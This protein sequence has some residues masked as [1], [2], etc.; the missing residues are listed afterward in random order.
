MQRIQQEVSD[1]R[2]LP[3]LAEVPN[4]IVPPF[5]AENML[6]EEYINEQMVATLNDEARTLTALGMIKPTYD[7]VNYALNGLI[8]N[9]GGF[10]R[11][12]RKVIYVLG[13]NFRAV[14]RLIYSHEYN[15]ALVDQSYDIA[16]LKSPE[17]CD[18]NDR[19]EAINALIEGDATLTMNQWLLQ[20][21]SP[22]DLKS[23]RSYR[24]PAQA[25]PEQSPPDYII[26][27]LNFPYEYGIRFVQSLYDEG[28]WTRVNQVYGQLPQST[29]QIMHFEKY[30]ASEAPIPVQDLPLGAVLGEA[31]RMLQ[32][33]TL[34][35]W[36][37]Y[38]ILAYGADKSAQQPFLDVETAAAGWGGD[39]YQAYFNDSTR[40]TVLAVHWVW[41][42]E[43]DA[44]E[45]DASMQA[46]L[47]ARFRGSKIPRSAGVCWE[48]NQQATC[49]YTFSAQSLWLL[50]PDQ[51]ILDQALSLYPQF[52]NP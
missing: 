32:S 4:Y 11:Y 41:D 14:E 36:G 10:Y 30:Q 27:A 25:L 38:L 37:S 48:I 26:H 22:A 42:T 15:H 16:S 13:L 34:G 24:P 40:Q 51:A 12:D 29:E 39:Q 21:A 49:L 52:A 9:Y 50:A 3:I 35:E 44:Q 5:I 8:D 17:N 43:L 1:L 31:W 47:D 45:F 19:C 7:L 18:N 2:G 6:R 46:Y 33:N 28:N 23:L 20:Y